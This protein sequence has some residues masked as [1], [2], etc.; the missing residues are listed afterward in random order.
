MPKSIAPRFSLLSAPCFNAVCEEFLRRSRIQRVNSAEFFVEYVLPRIP[1]ATKGPWMNMAASLRKSL[2][3]KFNKPLSEIKKDFILTRLNS[4]VATQKGIHYALNI[5]YSALQ[6]VVEDS[7]LMPL[8]DRI[9]L[10]FSAMN[11][12]N[13]RVNAIA[14]LRK[15]NR[16]EKRFQKSFTDAAYMDV[17][18]EDMENSIDLAD[19]KDGE[20]DK[21]LS[22]MLKK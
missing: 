22:E 14:A 8:K 6:S 21:E 3:K 13:N 10:L 11:A 2:E 15:D 9:A 12:Q 17:D 5:G 16:E 18:D 19:T 7:S 20:N 4:A 1:E